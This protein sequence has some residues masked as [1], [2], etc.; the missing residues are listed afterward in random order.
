MAINQEKE[1]IEEVM[2]RSQLILDTWY[3]ALSFTGRVLKLNKCF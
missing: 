2:A 3:Q 1:I